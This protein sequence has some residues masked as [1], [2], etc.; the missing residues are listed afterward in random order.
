MAG[1]AVI[2]GGPGGMMLAYLLGR[3]GIGVTLFETHRDFD[4]DFRGDSLHP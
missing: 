1:A 3:P 4:R 2:G